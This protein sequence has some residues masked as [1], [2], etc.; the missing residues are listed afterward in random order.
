[1]SA[2]LNLDSR[3][4]L[5]ADIVGST[6]LYETEGDARARELIAECLETIKALCKRHGG[7]VVAEVGDEVIAVFPDPGESVGAASEIHADLHE[8]A[9]RGGDAEQRLRLRIGLHY[10]PVPAGVELLSSETCKIAN[11]AAGNAKPEQTLATRRVIDELPRLFRAVS[12]YVDDETWN[13]VSLEHVELYEIIWDVES[14]TAYNGEK[15]DQDA[16]AYDAVTFTHGDQSVILDASRPVIS[17]GR[18]T[19]ND[20]V[21]QKDLVSRQHL[22]AQFSR[23]RCTI[24]DNSTNGS[25]VVAEDGNRYELKRESFRLMGSGRIIPGHPQ[26]ETPEFTIAFRCG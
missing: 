7:H 2:E 21:V 11:W 24:T 6:S 23:G 9:E 26:S 15:P 18:D 20:L 8:Q 14:I 25:V 22:S 1:M 3:V 4:I 10:G 5:S 17:I 19:N 16:Q 12:R 13:F